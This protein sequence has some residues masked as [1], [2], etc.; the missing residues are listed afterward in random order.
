MT[1]ETAI[2]TRTRNPRLLGKSVKIVDRRSRG[3]QL[4]YLVI[5]NGFAA[6]MPSA[7]VKLN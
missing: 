7:S 2:I 5:G 3:R 6:W 1:H 4:D